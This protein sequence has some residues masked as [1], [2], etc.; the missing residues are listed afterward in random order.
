MHLP[1]PETPLDT[2]AQRKADRAR[3]LRAFNLAFAAVLA[4]AAIFAVQPEF[5]VGPWTVRPRLSSPG[6][7]PRCTPRS[8]RRSRR[9]SLSGRGRRDCR[10]SPL[11]FVERV[12][13]VRQLPELLDRFLQPGYL[14]SASQAICIYPGEAAQGV[15]Y[16][17]G[18]YRQISPFDEAAPGPD[19]P[20][21]RVAMHGLARWT[22]PARALFGPQY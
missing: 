9:S 17:D 4:L 8:R 15:H 16:D 14:L 13:Q 12:R 2:P 3:W 7:T 22:L 20:R 18:F 10:R 1:M 5:N 11:L 19:A 6:Y 21:F